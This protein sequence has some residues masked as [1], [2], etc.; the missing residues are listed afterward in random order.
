MQLGICLFTDSLEPSG[1]GEH[2]LTL[3]AELRMRY[4]ISFG[5]IPNE[6]GVTLLKRARALGVDTLPLDG[7][8]TR[9]APEI[10]RLQRWLRDHRVDVFHLHAGVGWEGHTAI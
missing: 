5:C 8:G 9:L 3:A 10:V 6:P 2:M 1:V 4:R 7:R